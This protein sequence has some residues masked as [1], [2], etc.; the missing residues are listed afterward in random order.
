[1][2]Y[3]CGEVVVLGGGCGFSAHR[4]RLPDSSQ[5]LEG[6]ERQA[7]KGREP[8]GN[9]LLPTENGVDRRQKV[10]YGCG[11]YRTVVQADTVYS[12]AEGGAFQAMDGAGGGAAYRPD[13]GPGALHRTGG[14]RL[15]TAG[16]L[17]GL[18]QPA[19]A[20]HRGA[21]TLDR[22]VEEGRIGRGTAV[23]FADR[24][25]LSRLER[26]VG[27]GVQAAEGAQEGKSARQYDRPRD[28]HQHVGRSHHYA[29]IEEREPERHGRER[30]HRPP[31]RRH[32]PSGPRG[33][34]ERDWPVGGLADERQT[35][36]TNRRATHIC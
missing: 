10:S 35:D 36:C 4:Q 23:R 12:F 32:R 2:G 33:R 34:R 20:L 16:L 8:V 9:K 19:Y 7:G 21:Q 22:R 18:D 14:G 15:P 17:R 28:C 25:H 11:G 30:R 3:G 5:V 1:M 13:A 27:Q 24:H 29:D 26:P 6:T 31:R